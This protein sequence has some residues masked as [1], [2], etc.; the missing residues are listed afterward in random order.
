MENGKGKREAAELGGQGSDPRDSS[1]VIRDSG[2]LLF[3]SPSH[4][5]RTP[6]FPIHASPI[7]ESRST[8]HGFFGTSRSNLPHKKSS[9]LGAFF[10]LSFKPES[11]T[12]P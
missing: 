3:R 7:P 6:A 12:N 8:I 11:T 10:I 1:F 5:P 2:H 9:R 4:D